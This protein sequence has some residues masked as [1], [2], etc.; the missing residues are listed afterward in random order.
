MEPRKELQMRGHRVWDQAPRPQKVGLVLGGG[1]ARGIAHIG[2]LL[3]L[4]EHGIYPDVILALAERAHEVRPGTNKPPM[5]SRRCDYWHA[6]VP[7]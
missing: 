1:A 2:A 7:S 3:V 5:K 4:E 6:H